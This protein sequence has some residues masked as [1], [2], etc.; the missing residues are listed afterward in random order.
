MEANDVLSLC[1][2]HSSANC[3]EWGEKVKENQCLLSRNKILEQLK[4]KIVDL[5]S[6][7][8]MERG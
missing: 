5:S 6:A 4:Q 1:F 8:D 2:M 3:E 7:N